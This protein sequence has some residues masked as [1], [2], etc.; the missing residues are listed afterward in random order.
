MAR[1]VETASPAAD[2]EARNHAVQARLIRHRVGPLSERRGAILS[3]LGFNGPPPAVK[4]TLAE[5]EQ[6]AD[7]L[8]ALGGEA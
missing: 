7:E 8:D 6:A 5:L 4:P 1:R 2:T 3:S